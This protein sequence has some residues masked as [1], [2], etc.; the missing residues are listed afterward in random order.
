M[1][2]ARECPGVDFSNGREAAIRLTH[3]GAAFDERPAVI[4]LKTKVKSM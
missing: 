2:G 3:G 1:L 4:H